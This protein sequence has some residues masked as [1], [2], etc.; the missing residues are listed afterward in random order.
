LFGFVISLLLL[1]LTYVGYFVFVGVC[2]ISLFPLRLLM[3]QTFR[4]CLSNA[5]LLIYLLGFLVAISKKLVMRIDNPIASF[6]F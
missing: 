4:C 2:L 6:T 3:M 5:E 1:A